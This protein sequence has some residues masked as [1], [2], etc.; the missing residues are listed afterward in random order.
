MLQ[1]V[2]R[3]CTYYSMSVPAVLVAPQ[4][5]KKIHQAVNGFLM[6]LICQGMAD[7]GPNDPPRGIHLTNRNFIAPLCCRAHDVANPAFETK[8][9]MHNSDFNGGAVFVSKHDGGYTISKLFA[10]DTDDVV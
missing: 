3:V 1:Y 6:I 5:V 9:W 2:E 10:F 8:H 4:E 7:V